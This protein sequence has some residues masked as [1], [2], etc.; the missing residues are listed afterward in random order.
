[1]LYI[2]RKLNRRYSLVALL[3]LMVVGVVLLLTVGNVTFASSP[4]APL[5]SFICTP[6]AVGA[7]PGRVH[8]RCNPAAPGAISYFAVCVSNDAANANRFLSLFTTAKATGKNLAVYYTPSDTTGT[9]C[10]CA[11][12][13]CRL[14]YGAEVQQ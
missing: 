4:A 11:A 10:G 8:I 12:G 5:D 7:F 1:M 2:A 9:A 13:D 3:F 6:T 14:A